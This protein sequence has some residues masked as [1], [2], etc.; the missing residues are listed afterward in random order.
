MRAQPGSWYPRREAA[1][2]P[3]SSTS[4]RTRARW[5]QEASTL[6]RAK[7]PQDFPNPITGG[8]FTSGPG[9]SLINLS[10]KNP[11]GKTKDRS[12]YIA[13]LNV[14]GSGGPTLQWKPEVVCGK[15]IKG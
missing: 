10:R 1:I 13:V 6:V 15:N 8:E 12:I 2:S 11:A 14:T 4:R 5:T 7:C 3:R 9:L